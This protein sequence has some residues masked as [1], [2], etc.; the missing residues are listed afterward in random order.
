MS[1][2]TNATTTLFKESARPS[3]ELSG[4]VADQLEI[5]FTEAI[6]LL[7]K[8]KETPTVTLFVR[9]NS[10]EL[11]TLSETLTYL[12]Q[13]ISTAAGSTKDTLLNEISQ[14]L[15]ESQKKEGSSA[16]NYYFSEELK[17]AFQA[18]F[19]G[20]CELG[21]HPDPSAPNDMTKSIYYFHRIEVD[22]SG[23]K[24]ENGQDPQQYFLQFMEKWLMLR[25]LPRVAV[26]KN[27]AQVAVQLNNFPPARIQL[28]LN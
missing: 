21:V 9:R 2:P 13:Q 19:I 11:L 26:F 16:K 17:A 25:P 10:W 14:A 23:Y 4:A 22:L 6:A 15:A 27:A 5:P 7:E 20:R 3:I 24:T 1:T 8:L 12:Y 28:S 18:H